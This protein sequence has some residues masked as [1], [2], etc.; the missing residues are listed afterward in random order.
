MKFKIKK[1]MQGFTLLEVIISLIVAGIL[2]TMLVSFMGSSVV[3]SANPVL[4]AQNGAY[5]NQIMENITADYKYLMATSSTPMTDFISN[6]GGEGTSQTLY[7]DSSHPYTIV[8]NH[9]ISFPDGTSVPEETNSGG[10][11]LKV[12]VKYQNLTL[13]ALFAE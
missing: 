3:Q 11:I 7:A 13:T 2:G 12:T 5:V 6:I 4:Q 9:R 8:D 1:N 10:T